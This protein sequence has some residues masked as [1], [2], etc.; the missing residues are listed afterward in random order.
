MIT[1]KEA[2]TLCTPEKI[3]ERAAY[4]KGLHDAEV[5]TRLHLLHNTITNA[6]NGG[7]THFNA[8]CSDEIWQDVV[9]ALRAAEFEV[10]KRPAAGLG[11]SY[12]HITW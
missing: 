11:D 4:L 12:L 9:A 10:E 2:R 6:A 1:A 8:S 3:A 5:E 7:E